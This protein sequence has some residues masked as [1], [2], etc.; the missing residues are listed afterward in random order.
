MNSCKIFCT[1]F[2]LSITTFAD[3]L[4]KLKVPKA[5]FDFWNLSD[6]TLYNNNCYNYATNRV[7]NSFAQPGEA[8]EAMYESLTCESVYAAASKDLG[9]VPAKFTPM[10]SQSE[11]TLIALVVAPD[12]DFHWYRRDENNLW[13]HKMGDTEAKGIDES[14]KTIPDPETAD[15]GFYTEFCGY[16]NVKNTPKTTDEQNAGQVRIGNMKTLPGEN[17]DSVVVL[18]MFSGRK[19]PQINLRELLKQADIALELKEISKN[20][21]SR[22][23]QPT[24]RQA[25]LGDLNLHIVDREGLLFPKGSVIRVNEWAINGHD[26]TR[27]AAL[28][29]RILDFKKNK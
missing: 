11:E 3:I 4:P 7:T 9:L 29:Q 13:T 17:S 23:I 1:L 27:H 21:R 22:S 24:R 20:I 16:F 5:N 2:F 6:E 25:H 28:I 19:N 18:S 14:G 12:Y 8:S 15:R 10:K 26:R